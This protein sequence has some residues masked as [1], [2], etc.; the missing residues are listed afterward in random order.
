[1]T[2]TSTLNTEPKTIVASR[3]RR[4]VQLRWQRLKGT[5]QVFAESKLAVLGVIMIFIF[6]IMA[7]S[8]PILISTVWKPGIYDP[9]TGFDFDVFHPAAPSPAHILGTDFKGR[10]VLS[11]LLAATAPS[12][13]LGLTAGLVSAIV[14]TLIGTVSA[15]KGGSV[16]AFLFRLSDVFLMLPA[17]IVMV[18]LGASFRDLTPAQLG[19]LYGIVAGAGYSAVILRSHA[20]TVVSKPFIDAARIS[21]GGTRHIIFKHIMP[22]MLPMA[23]LQMMLAVTNAIV[24]DAFL[25]FL[26]I[27]R[28]TLNWGSLVYDSMITERTFRLAEPPWNTLVPPAMAISL[29][30][31]AFY[32]VSRG[33][34]R[35][36]DPRLRL[37]RR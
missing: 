1:M 3:S 31:F 5:W 21:G 15:Y 22:H 29:F 35:V 33:L 2:E 26:G 19:L 6:G 20:L 14:G 17:P 7:I 8:H 9:V 23:G 27:S 37:G 28:F 16:D 34:H 10:D 36:A 11:M 13:V 25:S 12:F 30:A 4:R 18:F 24:A 32:L